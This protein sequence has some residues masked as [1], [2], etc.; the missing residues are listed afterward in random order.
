MQNKRE[1]E[2]RRETVAYV[3]VTVV[4]EWS[5]DYLLKCQYHIGKDTQYIDQK[6]VCHS[7]SVIGGVGIG[8]GSTSNMQVS[9]SFLTDMGS[10]LHAQTVFFFAQCP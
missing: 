5:H 8:I 2:G 1:I 9:L 6:T 3:N 10:N 4:S 7:I